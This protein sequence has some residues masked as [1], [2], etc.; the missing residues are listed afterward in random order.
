VKIWYFQDMQLLFPPLEDNCQGDFGS[1]TG[2]VS[3]SK[4]RARSV[5]SQGLQDKFKAMEQ[6]WN[7]SN[8][9]RSETA[10][11]SSESAAAFAAAFASTS[12]AERGT[13]GEDSQQRENKKRKVAIETAFAI[14]SEVQKWQRGIAELE[15]MLN[16]A[17][18][19]DVEDFQGSSSSFSSSSSSSSSSSEGEAGARARPPEV[20][21]FPSL[22]PIIPA[23]EGDLVESSN[24]EDDGGGKN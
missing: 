15:A 8:T 9:Q 20:V 7:Q 1:K 4:S 24:N 2:E 12:A 3:K 11:S 5:M 23:E 22:P 10:C 16:V 21:R 17:S 18:G 6:T 19:G 14:E 13:E